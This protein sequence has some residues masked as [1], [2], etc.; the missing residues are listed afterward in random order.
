LGC[1]IVDLDYPVPV[2][3]ARKAMGPKQVLLG[4]LDPVRIVRNGTPEIVT[5]ALRE[6][7]RQAGAKFVVGAG[8]EIP[9]DTKPENMEALTAYARN[10]A[11]EWINA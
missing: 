9:R 11:A 4:N 8:C 3:A 10:H 2:D 5:A 6:C 7:H 1:D